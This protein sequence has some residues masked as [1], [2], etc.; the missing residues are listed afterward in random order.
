MKPITCD[1]A[2]ELISARLDGALSPDGEAAL[3]AHLARC[4]A[5][6]AL[7]ADLTE[8]HA[9]LDGAE[10]V[11][12]PADLKD[13]I[14]AAVAA[15]QVVPFP[16]P[17]KRRP[18]WRVWGSAAAVLALALL[19][20]GLLRGMNAGG[21]NAA[22]MAAGGAAPRAVYSAPAGAPAPAA[23]DGLAVPEAAAQ[24]EEPAESRSEGLEKSLPDRAADTGAGTEGAMPPAPAPVMTAPA[25]GGA[26]TADTLPEAVCGVLTLPA[27]D[28]PALDG[29]FSV[30]AE[31]GLH[32]YLPAADFQALAG[33]WAERGGEAPATEGGGIDP[34][35]E[36]GLVILTP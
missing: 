5:C 10:E 25:S 1:E 13:K 4:P 18:G 31:D 19:G 32:C 28:A 23:E 9:A 3:E 12:P 15:E 14:M 30:E 29:C 8:L 20:G 26:L 17:K 33:A 7:L 6:G 2:L 34:D 21:T 27:G 36:Y 22:P 16:A 24:A 35:A 11:P